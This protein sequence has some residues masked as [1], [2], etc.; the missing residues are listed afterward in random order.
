MNKIKQITIKIKLN[1]FY[2]N[3]NTP[4]NNFKLNNKILL[5]IHNIKI[6]NKYTMFNNH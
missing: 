3:I 4:N 1:N 2:N 5:I 6:N